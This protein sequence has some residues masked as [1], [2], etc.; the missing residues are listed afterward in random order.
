MDQAVQEYYTAAL[1]PATHKTYKAA[2]HKYLTFCINFNLSPLPTSECLLCYFVT[3]L[4]QEGLA[5]STIWSYVSGVHQ[6][7]IAA[8]FAD[9]QIDHMPWLRQVLKGIRVQAVRIGRH[10]CPCL[11]ITPSIFRKL[12]R[13]WLESSHTFNN[14]ML[15]AASTTTF[16]DFCRSGEVTVQCESEFDPQTHL[17]FQTLQWTMPFPQIPS[18]SS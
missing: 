14:A 1:T 12:R 8:I 16:F 15:W 9:P 7:Q 10:P 11:L 13:V 3:Y 18:P 4:G 6:T 2:E 17:G 5:S